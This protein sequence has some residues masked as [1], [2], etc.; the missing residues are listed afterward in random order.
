M[1]FTPD[2]KDYDLTFVFKQISG[3]V[4]TK[5]IQ[6]G[7]LI[8]ETQ[9]RQY[10]VDSWIHVSMGTPWRDASVCNEILRM[11]NGVYTLIE[12]C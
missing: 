9:E 8:W 10:G 2:V 11:E 5:Q 1:D 4:R 6:V 12:Q 3:M 7:Q